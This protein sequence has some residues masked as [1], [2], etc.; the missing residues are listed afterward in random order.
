MTSLAETIRPEVASWPGAEAK[1]HRFD[2]VE[3]RVR[4]H[5]IGDLHGDRWADL[6]FP[7]H[8]G[9]KLVAQGRTRLYHVLPQIE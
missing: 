2:R 5:E 6:P 1:P 4:G 3:F 8:V 9:K 7:V